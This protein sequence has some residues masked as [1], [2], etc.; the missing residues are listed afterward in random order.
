MWA[1]KIVIH[2]RITMLV[3]SKI[4]ELPIIRYK[5]SL[6]LVSQRK[7]KCFFIKNQFYIMNIERKKK[8]SLIFVIVVFKKSE[9]I[10]KKPLGWNSRQ[11]IKIINGSNC[12]INISDNCCMSRNNRQTFYLMICYRLILLFL[13]SLNKLT[14]SIRWLLLVKKFNLLIKL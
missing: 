5:C 3:L 2:L 7:R 11:T 6:R 14:I 13:S 1:L 10:K 12:C 4:L 8:Q 9:K